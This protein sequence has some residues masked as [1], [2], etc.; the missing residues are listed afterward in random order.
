MLFQRAIDWADI[1]QVVVQVVGI[2][3]RGLGAF[4]SETD[5]LTW[6][7]SRVGRS[8]SLLGLTPNF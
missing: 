5:M 4:A 2:D 3:C 7:R 6:F 8:R 1:V